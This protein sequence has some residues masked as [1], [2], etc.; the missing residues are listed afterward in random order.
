M[1]IEVG[2]NGP[3]SRSTFRQTQSSTT[4]YIF[5]TICLLFLLVSSARAEVI[6]NSPSNGATVSGTVT[7][8]AQ[9]T[10]AWWSKLWVDGKGVATASVGLVSFKWDSASV[11]DGSHTL[12][13]AAYLSGAPANA[14]ETITVVV[15][16]T[17]SGGGYHFSTLPRGAPLPGDATCAAEIPWE[18]EMVLANE[19]ANTTKPSQ[20]QLDAYAANGYAADV[21]NGAWAY[22]R[23][24]GQY[25]GTTDM[26]FRWAACKWG[27]DEDVIRAQATNEDWSWDQSR[28]GDKRTSYSQ[29]VNGRF[30][31]LWDYECPSCCY[32]SW[33]IFQTKALYNWQTWPMLR[34]STAFGADFH[35]ASMRSCMDGDLAGYFAG[36]P[37]Y[38][39]HTYAGDIASG[40]LSTI[41]WGCIGYHYSGNWYNG[42]SSYGAIWY[43]DHIKESLVQ[44]TWKTRWPWVNW[45]D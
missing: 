23:V 36:R 16:N 18:R 27:I 22:R 7:V 25:T 21:Y 32:Q 17:G 45:P 3:V 11:S 38:N 10:D 4:K 14:A 40:D 28:G 1:R 20:A 33:S 2:V 34:S 31:S 29:C 44:K 42:D 15:N 39:G 12:K 30:T 35:F 24:D 19:G 26:I 9:I 43:I 5:L 13:V 6:I 41:M 8:K 37:A